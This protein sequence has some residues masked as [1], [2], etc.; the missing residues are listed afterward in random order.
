MRSALC[1]CSSDFAWLPYFNFGLILRSCAVAEI[2]ITP[3]HGDLLS[4]R[5]WWRRI[6]FCPNLGCLSQSSVYSVDMSL[7]IGCPAVANSNLPTWIVICRVS[8]LGFM[9]NSVVSCGMTSRLGWQWRGRIQQSGSSQSVD[10]RQSIIAEPS[11][12][13][14]CESETVYIMIWYIYIYIHYVKCDTITVHIVAIY[15]HIDMCIIGLYV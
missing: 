13:H 11:S 2:L 12:V 7:V 1:L 9:S 3:G 10:S 14:E 15:I 5:R 6:R 4:S 8:P